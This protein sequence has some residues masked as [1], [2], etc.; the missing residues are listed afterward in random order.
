M[1]SCSHQPRQG[2]QPVLSVCALVDAPVA[3][4][5]DYCVHLQCQARH[6]RA[7]P[8][9][10]PVP[11]HIPPSLSAGPTQLALLATTSRRLLR[12]C[13]PKRK[14][15]LCLPS[16]TDQPKLPWLPWLPSSLSSVSAFYSS[17]INHRRLS[18]RC[19][20]P[21]ASLV[22]RRFH[23]ARFSRPTI[24]IVACCIPEHLATPA[25]AQQRRPSRPPS[26]ALSLSTRSR[27]LCDGKASDLACQ[28]C[29]TTTL[30]DPNLFIARS[31]CSCRLRL[32]S[33]VL[34]Q[35]ADPI[36]LHP[37]SSLLSFHSSLC[38]TLRPLTGPR[39][40]RQPESRQLDAP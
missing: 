37:S 12:A 6:C 21:P 25:L 20:L 15:K 35:V 16:R 4:G 23:V 19:I 36:P 33:L 32:R 30:T 28:R 29:A 34:P 5:D 11:S 7:P 26:L 22:L 2:S 24:G 10:H 40:L 39:R 31:H 17:T 3:A 18:V 14:P 1:A 8:F 38:P 13:P 9:P 27:P